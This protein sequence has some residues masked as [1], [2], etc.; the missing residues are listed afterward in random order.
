MASEFSAAGA[1]VLWLPS[2]GHVLRRQAARLLDEEMERLL[3]RGQQLQ[4]EQGE[5]LA[6]CVELRAKVAECRQMLHKSFNKRQQVEADIVMT[7]SS[8]ENLKQVC[9]LRAACGKLS[10]AK[11]LPKLLK[12]R[13]G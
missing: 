4:D 6:S 3:E 2:R 1:A 13:R 10:S 9:H 8:I 12:K 7:R 5:H 11:L